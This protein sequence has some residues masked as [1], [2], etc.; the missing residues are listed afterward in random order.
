MQPH[1]KKE[2]R[3]NYVWWKVINQ[4]WEEEIKPMNEPWL[5]LPNTQH[6]LETG[7][8]YPLLALPCTSVPIIPF[9][10]LFVYC[11]FV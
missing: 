6:I 8:L 7:S 5:I 11:V 9:C 1:Q 10:Y 3:Y 2:Q 4:R